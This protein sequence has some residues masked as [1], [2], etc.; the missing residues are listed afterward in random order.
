VA[1]GRDN[2]T[3]NAA[4]RI[5]NI[6]KY[7]PALAGLNRHPDSGERAVKEVRHALQISVRAQFALF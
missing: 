1:F 2:V 5:R 7:L 4:E 3:A 6:P